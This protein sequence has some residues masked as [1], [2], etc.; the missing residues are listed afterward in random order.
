[1]ETDLSKADTFFIKNHKGL[2]YKIF[3]P[4]TQR[5]LQIYFQSDFPYNIIG[6]QEKYPDGFGADKKMLTTSAILKKTIWLDYWKHNTIADSTFLN[7][8]EMMRYE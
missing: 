5:T 4:T 3:Y 7:S 2:L 8:L 6:W 1:M